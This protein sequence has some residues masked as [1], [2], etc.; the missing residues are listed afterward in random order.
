MQKNEISELMMVKAEYERQITN[1][2]RSNQ[3]FYAE[4][5]RLKQEVYNANNELI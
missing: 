1:L 4:N 2:V 3:E 5:I